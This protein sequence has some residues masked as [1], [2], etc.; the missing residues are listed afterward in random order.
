MLLLD[1]TATL[2]GLQAFGQQRLHSF[3]TDPL[4]PAR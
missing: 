4:A 1:G 3:G 2:R